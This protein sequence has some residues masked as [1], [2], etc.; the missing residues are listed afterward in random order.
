VHSRLCAPRVP[1]FRTVEQ[2][3]TMAGALRAGAL[4]ALLAASACA[5]AAG[6]EPVL[7]AS[8]ILSAPRAQPG[9]AGGRRAG[10][11]LRLRGGSGAG[12]GSPQ[13]GQGG[14]FGGGGSGS[15]LGSQQF[16][17]PVAQGQQQ[18]GFNPFTQG[19]QQQVLDPSPACPMAPCAAPARERPPAARRRCC[20][21]HQ[22]N[23]SCVQPLSNATLPCAS[24]P[25]DPLQGY[26]AHKNQQPPRTLQ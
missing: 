19:Q 18:G 7:H 26:L 4:R 11:L 16:L 6:L 3:G 5:A 13:Q 9:G 24:S 20:S 17:S 15:P 25:S 22:T 1:L 12:W 8:G 21:L 10:A 23:H 2:I 14:L